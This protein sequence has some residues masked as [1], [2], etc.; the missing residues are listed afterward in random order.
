M[1]H[2]GSSLHHSADS[3]DFPFLLDHVCQDPEEFGFFK[4]D[5]LVMCVLI[6]GSDIGLT[7]TP[8]HAGAV[9]PEVNLHPFPSLGFLS[10][11]DDLLIPAGA[12]SSQ[13]AEAL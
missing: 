8:S 10:L 5:T 7:I 4:E 9:N 12:L 2:S 11:G 6:E 1:I 3:K 13:P